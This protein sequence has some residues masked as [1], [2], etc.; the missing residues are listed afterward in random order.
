MIVQ[1]IQ[2]AYRAKDLAPPEAVTAHSTSSVSMSWAASQHV[3]PDVI[4]KVALR[5]SSNTFVALYCVEPAS[6]SYVKLDLKVPFVD[7]KN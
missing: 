4:C 3:A 6:L 5:S 1:A 2:Q 7:G